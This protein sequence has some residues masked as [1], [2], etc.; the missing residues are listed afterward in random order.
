MKGV[1]DR[2]LPQTSSI[3]K[4]R[5]NLLRHALLSL[6]AVA[7]ATSLWANEPDAGVQAKVDVKIAEIKSWTADPAVVAAVA[8]HNGS[9]PADHAALTQEKWSALSL[10]DPV[11][12]S[13]SKNAAAAVLKAKRGPWTAE[14]FISDAKGCKVAFLAKTSKWCH[15]GDAKHDG[16][17]SGQNWQG[18]I[19]VDESSG[20]QQL[21][22][23]VP[24]LND[25]Q[26]IGSL[27]VGL[28]LGKL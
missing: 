26:P 8:A 14:A 19:A 24:V 21:Q 23:A 28:S 16:P 11:V 3:M 25:G 9:M 17:M 6:M 13:F 20:L 12:R 15:A 27:V 1:A 4:S 5:S 2:R 22:I 7:A 18:E 10:L